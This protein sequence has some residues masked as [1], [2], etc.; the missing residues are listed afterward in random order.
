M[1]SPPPEGRPPEEPRSREE[2][3]RSRFEDLSN[4]E[5]PVAKA[6]PPRRPAIV[7]TASVVLFVSALMNGIVVVAFTP[8]GASLWLSSALA[9]CQ[10]LGSALVVLLVPVGRPLGIALG[11]VG[12]VIGIAVAADGGAASG[13]VTI[14]LN[15]FV[16]YALAASGPSFHRG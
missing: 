10:A 6:A 8:T 13:L 14:G 3:A 16:V 4:L 15:G 5:V 2:P 11:L 7:T 12:M 9:V 1:E